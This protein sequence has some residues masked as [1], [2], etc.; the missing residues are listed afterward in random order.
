VLWSAAFIGCVRHVRIQ[1]VQVSP[2][3]VVHS[4]LGVGLTLGDCE[5]V[6]W[7]R[8][9]GAGGETV[10]QHGGRCSS[11]WLRAVCNC[12]G[13]YRGQFCEMCRYL[14]GLVL[15]FILSLTHSADTHTILSFQAPPASRLAIVNA[16]YVFRVLHS[17]LDKD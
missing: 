10:C 17:E 7:C 15:C 11:S 6:D 9:D 13:D 16:V 2:V 3:K 14:Y 1:A 8:P 5:L 4:P 12:T